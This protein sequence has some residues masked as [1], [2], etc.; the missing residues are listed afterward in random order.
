[1]SASH[2]GL[3]TLKSCP[4]DSRFSLSAG[5]AKS[6]LGDRPPE[7]QTSTISYHTL[8]LSHSMQDTANTAASP[9]P[10]NT[11]PPQGT[12]DPLP[13][14]QLHRRSERRSA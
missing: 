1:M 9:T 7:R 5:E 3:G 2:S 8:K 12:G 4:Q 6:L 11:S 13:L 10:R 14:L